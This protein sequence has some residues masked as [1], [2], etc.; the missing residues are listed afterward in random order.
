MKISEKNICVFCEKSL[1]S[2]KNLDHCQLTS[3]YRVPAYNE[4]KKTVAQK[5]YFYSIRDFWIQ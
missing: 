4:R 3:K 5:K 1:I 2:N